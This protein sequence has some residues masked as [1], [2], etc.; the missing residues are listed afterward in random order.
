MFFRIYVLLVITATGFLFTDLWFVAFLVLLWLLFLLIKAESYRKKLKNKK[1]LHEKTLSFAIQSIKKQ[2]EN[3]SFINRICLV[4]PTLRLFLKHLSIL[5]DDI[6]I[7]FT[8]GTRIVFDTRENNS[9]SLGP[10]YPSQGVDPSY[11]ACS[12]NIYHGR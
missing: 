11:R 6:G 12:D 2:K 1:P 10:T 5:L 4:F 3:F 9:P 7:E 8:S